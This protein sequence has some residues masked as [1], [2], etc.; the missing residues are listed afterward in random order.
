MKE[1]KSIK[2]SELIPLIGQAN[3]SLNEKFK[4]NKLINL[5]I[6]DVFDKLLTKIIN[7]SSSKEEQINDSFIDED[8]K[9]DNPTR[10]LVNSISKINYNFS[11]KNKKDFFNLLEGIKKMFWSGEPEK[12]IALINNKEDELIKFFNNYNDVKEDFDEQSK[13]IIFEIISFLKKNNF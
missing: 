13:K 9:S 3:E 2:L 8:I 1:Q 5:A 11:L 6:D 12:A 10:A 4:K 7:K